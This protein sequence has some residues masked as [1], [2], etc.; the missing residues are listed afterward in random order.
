MQMDIMTIS[1]TASYLQV[2]EKQ[3]EDLLRKKN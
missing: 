3:Y 1:Q 2:C